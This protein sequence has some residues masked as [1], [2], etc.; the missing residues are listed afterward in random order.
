VATLISV[1]IRFNW[2]IFGEFVSKSSPGHA[3]R[4]CFGHG[5]KTVTST[6][7]ETAT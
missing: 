3:L 5:W 4:D 6:P 1:K 7:A 2:F